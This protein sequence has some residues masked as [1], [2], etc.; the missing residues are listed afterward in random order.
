M[1]D[2]QTNPPKVTNE[3]V[4]LRAVS[5]GQCQA[6]WSPR[7]GRAPGAGRG[8]E[9]DPAAPGGNSNFHGSNQ[10]LKERTLSL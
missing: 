1:E 9:P 7:A 8:A 2:N 4:L 3:R 10:Q 5:G 6:G